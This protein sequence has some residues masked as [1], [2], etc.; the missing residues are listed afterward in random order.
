VQKNSFFL[1]KAPEIRLFQRFLGFYPF[2]R[3]F[4]EPYPVS[5]AGY[6]VITG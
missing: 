3:E 6:G 1:Q 2:S 5:Y 4:E